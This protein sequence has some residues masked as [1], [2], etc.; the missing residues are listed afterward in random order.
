MSFKAARIKDFGA[1]RISVQGYQRICYWIDHLKRIMFAWSKRVLS[2]LACFRTTQN[3][4]K[5]VNHYLVVT[6]QHLRI[7][8]AWLSIPSWGTHTQHREPPGRRS[9][10]CST[11]WMLSNHPGARLLRAFVKLFTTAEARIKYKSNNSW[12]H[13]QEG[14]HSLRH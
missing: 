5:K 11:L 7:V 14:F 4:N 8:Y 9:E 3:R 10:D 1:D 2:F 6:L 13:V 12:N